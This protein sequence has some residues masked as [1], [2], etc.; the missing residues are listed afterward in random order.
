MENINEI[1]DYCNN[2]QITEQNI[3]ASKKALYYASFNWNLETIYSLAIL[4]NMFFIDPGQKPTLIGYNLTIS[5]E[6]NFPN[7][8]KL[9]KYNE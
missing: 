1:I 8:D 9:E 2:F 5:F 7:T 6:N 4:S 3:A